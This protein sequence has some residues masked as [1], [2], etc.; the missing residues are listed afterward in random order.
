MSDGFHLRHD[1]VRRSFARAAESYDAAAVLQREVLN[2]LVERLDLVSLKPVVVLDAGTGTG[3]GA[4]ALSD[5][6]RRARV[7]AL[8]IAEPMA[9]RAQRRRR[10]LRKVDAVCADAERLPLGAATVDLV[11]SNLM[12]QWLD[13]PAPAFNEFRRVL[14][15]GGLLLFTS[16]GPDTLKELRAAWR[17]V[18]ENVHVN[19]FLD[20]HDVGDALVRS[21]FRDPVMDVERMTVTYE[22]TMALM[23][24]LQA[25]GARNVN[26]GRPRGLT[27]PRRLRAMQAE[28]EAFRRDG[29]LPA[30]WEVVFGQAWA[31]PAGVA[32]RDPGQ[33]GEARIPIEAIARRSR[34]DR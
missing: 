12:L 30:S 25:I 29:S 33:P 10:W 8:D 9:A 3:L 31:P 28:Y 4:A 24:D 16:F 27:G 18:D 11:F 19:R 15:P 20:M 6:F 2:R 1:R 26:A 17:A 22:D 23:R 34:G 14:K 32:H 21:G 7:V 13:D 5:R